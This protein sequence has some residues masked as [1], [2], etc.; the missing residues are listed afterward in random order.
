MDLLTAIPGVHR[1]PEYYLFI[2]ITFLVILVSFIITKGLAIRYFG[3]EHIKSSIRQT[4]GLI[5]LAVSVVVAVYL[6]NNVLNHEDYF[7]KLYE[8]NG[9]MIPITMVVIAFFLF[10]V[11]GIMISLITKSNNKEEGIIDSK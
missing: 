7:A 11:I 1:G 8:S 10:T 3:Y 6:P 4:M 2:G 9:L 5:H